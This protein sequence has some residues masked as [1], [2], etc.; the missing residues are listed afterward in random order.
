MP[1]PAAFLFCRRGQ[2]A[3]EDAHALIGGRLAQTGRS[4]N[5]PATAGHV[6]G[7]SRPITEHCALNYVVR[8]RTP[9]EFLVMN[10]IIY[11]VGLVVIVLALLSLVGLR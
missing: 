11:L 7:L 10:G 8:A 9:K 3:R 4:V 6:H 2:A 5:P 1:A